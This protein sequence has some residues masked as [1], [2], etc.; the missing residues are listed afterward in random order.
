MHRQLLRLF[1][2]LLIVLPC[3]RAFADD[4]SDAM[5]V[6]RNAGESGKFFAD[7]YGYAVFPTIGKAG[8]FVGGAY[9]RGRVYR[10]GKYVGDA[11][12]TQ[13]TVG[14][15]LGGQVYSEIVFFRN[16]AAF[17][18][19]TSGEFEFGA[20]AAAVAMTAGALA[21]AGTSGAAAGASG[22]QNIATTAGKYSRGMAVFTIAKGG[23]MYEASVGGERFSYSPL[24]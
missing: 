12:M 22:A 19:F 1:L 6:F 24:G 13:F 11:T 20:Q 10:K 21:H 9:G 18:K 5:Q 4:Y 16:K 7:S 15:Q 23:L 14:A 8:M 3:A 17:D 2:A